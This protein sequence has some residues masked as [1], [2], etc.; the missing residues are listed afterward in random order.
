MK[1][2][3]ISISVS[4]K[5]P[6]W[7]GDTPYS[8]GW[9]WD[10][11]KG[12]SVN[13]SSLTMSPHVGTHAD[14]PIH[15]SPQGFGA[16]ELPLDA[17]Y[18]DVLVVD[19]SG[20]DVNE[21]LQQTAGEISYD[22]IIE[23]I[24]EAMAYGGGYSDDGSYGGDDSEEFIERILLKTGRTI[25]SGR[26]PATWPAVSAECARELIGRGLKLLGVDCPSVDSKES[27]TLEVHHVLFDAGAFVLENLD[28][29]HVKPGRY[30]LIAFPTKFEGL[31]G[32]P[33]R[34]VLRQRTLS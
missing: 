25:A 9:T 31:D 13:V 34:A 12:A 10:M 23:Q 7:P 2:I 28:L 4:D 32:A 20:E 21:A 1:L 16:S 17:F 27:K 6:E 8:C 18:G 26:F 29:S 30:E 3:D 11:A 14:A 22:T 24:G 19:V 5:T 15:V 33:V